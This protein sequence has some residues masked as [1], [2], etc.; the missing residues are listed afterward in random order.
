MIHYLIKLIIR[1]ELNKIEA[2][3][4]SQFYDILCNKY[5]KRRVFKLVKYKS[6]WK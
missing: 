2:S 1:R 4:E 3:S 6:V 5:N